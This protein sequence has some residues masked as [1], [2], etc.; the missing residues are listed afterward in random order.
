MPVEPFLEP[1]HGRNKRLG[2]E[3][4]F[5][6]NHAVD[7][8][9]PRIGLH[10][11]RLLPDILRRPEFIEI[12][13][14]GGHLLVGHRAVEA[15]GAVAREGITTDGGQRGGR[16]ESRS[17]KAEP[18]KAGTLQPVAAVHPDGFRRGGGFGQLPAAAGADQHVMS[19]GGEARCGDNTLPL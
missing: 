2:I 11:F 7:G 9:R 14:G 12:G 15:V 5:T 1:A 18:G 6:L 8:H 13:V 4:H 17:G 10:P 16:R 3:C 19:P